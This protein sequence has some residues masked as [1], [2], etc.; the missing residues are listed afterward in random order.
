MLIVGSR[1]FY[2]LDRKIVSLGMGRKVFQR[3]H[4]G[5]SLGISQ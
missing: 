2:A 3:S 1:T 5:A 4:F